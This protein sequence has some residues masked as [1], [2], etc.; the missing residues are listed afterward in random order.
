MTLA[1]CGCGA[2]TLTVPEAPL[3]VVA[4]HCRDCQRRTGAPFGVGAF[5]RAE[6][7]AISGERRE[8]VRPAESGAMVHNSF[9]PA[10][11]TTLCWTADALPGVIGVALDDSAGLRPMR[12]VFERAK[13]WWVE[14]DGA[15]EHFPQGSAG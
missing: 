4:C 13:R 2:L 3:M 10:C 1:R 15:V 11:G 5:Y 7:V 8:F 12:S 14:I 6:A 9:C